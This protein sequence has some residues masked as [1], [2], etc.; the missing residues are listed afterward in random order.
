MQSKKQQY[1][2]KS[3]N[4]N[5]QKISI[6]NRKNT[7]KLTFNVGWRESLEVAGVLE[8][9]V[10][11]IPTQRAKLLFHGLKIGSKVRVKE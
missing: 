8:F 9:T 4:F 11:F 1:P 5:D 7:Q 2:T 10:A 3:S 6:L